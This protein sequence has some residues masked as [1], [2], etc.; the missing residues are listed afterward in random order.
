MAIA[1]AIIV[2]PLSVVL[3][4]AFIPGFVAG[5]ATFLY[6]REPGR[7]L[8]TRREALRR[9]CSVG[10]ATGAGTVAVASLVSGLLSVAWPLL[11][12]CVCTS[13]LVLRRVG[14]AV[15]SAGETRR[16]RERA[17]TEEAAWWSMLAREVEGLADGELCR[18]WRGSYSALLEASDAA[19]AAQVVRVRQAYLDELDRRHQ[20]AMSE[21]LASGPRPATGPERFLQ[22]PRRRDSV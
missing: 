16:R 21:W 11:V 7:P 8:A 18:V 12:L 15:R 13:P 20:Q 1:T 19:T 2:W 3:G 6:Y 22:A 4:L 10:T 9:S 5:F 17:R 14:D